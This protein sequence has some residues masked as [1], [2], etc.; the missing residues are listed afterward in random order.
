MIIITSY[1]SH[2]NNASYSNN[3]INDII[4]SNYNN[5]SDSSNDSNKKIVNE[6]VKSQAE[7]A[8]WYIALLIFHSVKKIFSDVVFVGI[9]SLC[10]FQGI[11]ELFQIFGAI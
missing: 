1:N 10:C 6:N 4:N 9:K 5:N 7:V 8:I 3:N 2:S 11:W